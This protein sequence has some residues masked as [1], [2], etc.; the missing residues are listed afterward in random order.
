[1]KASNNLFFQYF[2]LC[3]LNYTITDE[4]L[5]K[6]VQLGYITQEEYE[7]IVNTPR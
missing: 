5:Q 3:W 7:I 4:Q 1:M 2:L 6:A